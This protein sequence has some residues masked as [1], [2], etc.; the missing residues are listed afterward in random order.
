MNA[1][2][3]CTPDPHCILRPVGPARGHRGSD[4]GSTHARDG[5]CWIACGLV[6]RPSVL[7]RTFEVEISYYLSQQ[8]GMWAR[9]KCCFLS[10]QF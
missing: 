1:N 8:P 10:V 5:A 4:C 9:A 3:A 7:V 2:D 6:D